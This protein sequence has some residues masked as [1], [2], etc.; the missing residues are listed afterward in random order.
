MFLSLLLLSLFSLFSFFCKLEAGEVTFII[1]SALVDR[2][3]VGLHVATRSRHDMG[4][5]DTYFST[6][7]QRQLVLL[8]KALAF[9]PGSGLAWVGEA[10]WWM[11]PYSGRLIVF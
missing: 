2:V 6:P 10:P 1:V 11:M 3:E 5:K 7:R 4:T 9:L 8:V